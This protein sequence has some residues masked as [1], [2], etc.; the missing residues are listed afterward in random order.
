MKRQAGRDVPLTCCL[1]EHDLDMWKRYRDAGAARVIVEVPPEGTDTVLPMLDI[2][3]GDA[4]FVLFRRCPGKEH[5]K[6]W[7]DLCGK[8][9]S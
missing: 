6:S 8:I 7:V 4:F 3:P 2:R 5:T 1:A 9:L